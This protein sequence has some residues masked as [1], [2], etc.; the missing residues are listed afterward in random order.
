MRKLLKRYLLYRKLKREGISKD[1]R[2][3]R[4][5]T[6]GLITFEQYEKYYDNKVKKGE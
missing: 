2:M 4:Y 5:A 6:E 1:L 3:I